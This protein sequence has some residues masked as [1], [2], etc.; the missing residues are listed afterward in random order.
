[1]YITG[2]NTTSSSTFLIQKR[3]ENGRIFRRAMKKVKLPVL[4]FFFLFRLF[5]SKR[6]AVKAQ[7]IDAL[8]SRASFQARGT[9]AVTAQTPQLQPQNTTGR[10]RARGEGDKAAEAKL[11]LQTSA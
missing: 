8:H 7:R 4:C 1:V 10:P 5:F 2:L 6:L 3:K 9:H 11:K